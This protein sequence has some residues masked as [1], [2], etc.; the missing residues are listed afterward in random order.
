MK[1]EFPHVY[2][3][4]LNLISVWSDFV[5]IL[6]INNILIEDQL[7]YTLRPIY[8]KNMLNFI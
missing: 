4:K 1:I 5:I 8:I 6:E 3:K 2:L 7:K